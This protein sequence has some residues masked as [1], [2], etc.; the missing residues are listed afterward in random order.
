MAEGAATLSVARPS[1]PLSCCIIAKNEGDRIAACIAAV[2]DLAHEIVVVD[3]G[4]T[5]DTVAQAEAMGAK[6][7]FRAWDGYGPQKR[8]AEDCAAHDWILNLDADEV[9]TE[10]LRDEIRALLQSP[11]AHAAYRIKLV[12]VAPG[13]TRARLWA[14]F[15][16]YVRLYDRRRVRFRESLV[17]DTVDT[18]DEPVGQLR[19]QALH[20]SNRSLEHVRRKLD[21]Y[22]ALQ[23]KELRKSP[24]VVVIRLPFEYP[25]VF[26]R[27]YLLRRNFTDG[28]FGLQI[29]HLAAQTRVRRLLRILQA[30]R[31]RAVQA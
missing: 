26:I 4:S 23:A 30:Q 13:R 2:R 17:H 7:F 22:T 19:G 1:V 29:S 25:L 21:R 15:H 27:Y 5:D 6:V 3:S 20:F 31:A 10:G 18:R 9:L 14:D 12:Q 28:L 11:P 16:N 24:L 8:F